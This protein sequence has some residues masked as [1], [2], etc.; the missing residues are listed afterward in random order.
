MQTARVDFLLS[1]LPSR[2]GLHFFFRQSREKQTRKFGHGGNGVSFL[3]GPPDR[4][5]VQRVAKLSMEFA[6]DSL[7]SRMPLLQANRRK[8]TKVCRMVPGFGLALGAFCPELALAGERTSEYP[9]AGVFKSSLTFHKFFYL[10]NWL[11][12]KSMYLTAHNGFC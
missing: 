8:L 6:D 11:V 2:G 10:T 1:S 12:N 4:L 5:D 9:V 3:D 7:L